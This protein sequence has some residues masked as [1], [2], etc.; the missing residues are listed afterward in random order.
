MCAG[1]VYPT[2]ATMDPTMGRSVS[3]VYNAGRTERPRSPQF[4]HLRRTS[5]L[6]SLFCVL[7]GVVGFGLALYGLTNSFG[8]DFA[9]ISM[10]IMLAAEILLIFAGIIGIVG[11]MKASTR[12]LK[13][14]LGILLICVLSFTGVAV[15][16]HLKLINIKHKVT[17]AVEN[18]MDMYGTKMGQFHHGDQTLDEIQTEHACCGSSSPKQWGLTRYGRIPL[19]CCRNIHECSLILNSTE[20]FEQQYRELYNLRTP[21]GLV[22]RRRGCVDVITSLYKSAQDIIVACAG[23]SAV[24]IFLCF[25]LVT[26]FCCATQRIG[27]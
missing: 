1:N 5:V 20:N 21:S 24:F 22:L 9:T 15:F 10:S 17:K 14:A 13:L 2:S 12:L 23:A 19:S 26:S 18:F 8:G 7:C 11:G 4:N 27:L 6:F 25:V 16:T 3:Q